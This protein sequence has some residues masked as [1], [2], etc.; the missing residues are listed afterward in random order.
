MWP[1]LVFQWQRQ[2]RRLALPSRSRR[3]STWQFKEQRSPADLSN[4]SRSAHLPGLLVIWQASPLQRHMTPSLFPCRSQSSPGSKG[5]HGDAEDS[6]QGSLILTL[7]NRDRLCLC[8][9][10]PLHCNLALAGHCCL[11]PPFG[12]RLSVTSWRRT[13]T[14]G[15]LEWE[16]FQLSSQLQSPVTLKL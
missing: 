6:R 15:I 14:P 1:S 2:P 4:L 8:G 16:S 7:Q 13:Q 11:K 5:G 3:N 10:Q 9:R 12:R